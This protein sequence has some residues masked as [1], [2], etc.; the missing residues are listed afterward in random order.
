MMYVDLPSKMERERQRC[1]LSFPRAPTPSLSASSE[2]PQ[3]HPPCCPPSSCA[4][5]VL[6]SSFSPHSPL[7]S[8]S[9]FSLASRRSLSASTPARRFLSSVSSAS[10]PPPASSSHSSAFASCLP[11]REDGGS[12][13]S[14]RSPAFALS[15]AALPCASALSTPA[16][17]RL[18]MASQRVQ[19]GNSLSTLSFYKESA[20]S[21]LPHGLPT[22]SGRETVA[23]VSSRG[24]Q[25]PMAAGA[26]SA[27]PAFLPEVDEDLRSADCTRRKDS[28]DGVASA[29]R[30]RRRSLCFDTSV[31]T[32]SSSSRQAEED[33]FR[34][35][36]E[37]PHERHPT[38]DTELEFF[39]AQE[40]E[41]DSPDSPVGET[42]SLFWEAERDGSGSKLVT[43]SQMRQDG[44]K[45][46]HD[47]AGEEAERQ[48]RGGRERGGERRG[49]AQCG[50][51]DGNTEQLLGRHAFVSLLREENKRPGH[52]DDYL[53][54][55]ASPAAD[56]S[57]VP[58]TGGSST[59]SFFAAGL[60]STDGFQATAKKEAT[61]RETVQEIQA[62]QATIVRAAHGPLE[63]YR[64][65]AA[66]LQQ[67]LDL[68]HERERSA[69]RILETLPDRRE[70][71]LS[72]LKVPP[73]PPLPLVPVRWNRRSP[74]RC[75]EEALVAAEALL[76]CSDPSAV[77]I[78]KFNIG[79]TAGQLECLYG[80]NWLNDEVINF[81]MQMLQERNKK[82]RAL[83]QNIWKT[84][85]FNTFFYAKLTGGH[86]ADVTYDF[87]SVRRWTR[88]QNVDIFAVDLILIPL[89]VNRLHWTLGVVDMRKGKR[90]IYFFDSLGG[91]NKTWFATMRRYLQDEHADKRGKP[92][93]DIEEW[94]I[95]D[96]FAS[97]KYTPQQANGFDC[98][99]FICQM[100][101]CITDGRSF[102]FSQ[103]DIPHIRRKMALQIVG[104]EL[105]P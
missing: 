32:F 6:L 65:Y 102:D 80:S 3:S 93:E 91:T 95:P 97:E 10:L 63:L 37:A 7:S 27:S 47:Q 62:R 98:G 60:L 14:R 5:R 2:S 94:C 31:A 100:A 99:V 86:S 52:K 18:C 12:L 88:R 49:G 50:E 43:C 21:P 69:R 35:R 59:S 22:G 85:F 74:M 25:T 39:D 68:L 13:S 11:L 55:A 4:S 15:A 64:S 96:D 103:K 72:K 40:R 1:V 78:D 8:V 51:R 104:G 76:T 75:D 83:G 58:C 73:P 44:L 17:P 26:G 24:V 84:F 92:L 30:Q 77:L 34:D 48:H 89:H 57:K 82:Q 54:A 38:Q 70:Q 53:P 67:K 20:A 79:L 46:D 19:S 23:H 28:R 105:D 41:T 81:Y 66:S 45:S 29:D 36:G 42:A 71:L 61:R 90:K 16:E 33:F 101:E 87:A 9:Y 56:R